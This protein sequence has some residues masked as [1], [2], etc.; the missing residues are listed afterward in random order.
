MK[1]QNNTKL[2]QCSLNVK[3]IRECMF[4]GICLADGVCSFKKTAKNKKPKKIRKKS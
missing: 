2:R 1:K 3:K 4:E